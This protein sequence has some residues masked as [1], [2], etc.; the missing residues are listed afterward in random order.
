MT[1][2]LFEKALNSSVENKVEFHQGWNSKYKSEIVLLSSKSFFCQTNKIILVKDKFWQDFLETLR[3]NTIVLVFVSL[4]QEQ[5]KRIF[6][7][8][9]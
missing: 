6:E 1:L 7:T 9:W 5:K 2:H 4:K 8:C 3:I